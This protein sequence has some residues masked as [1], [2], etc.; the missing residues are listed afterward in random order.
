M[1]ER[2]VHEVGPHGQPADVALVEDLRRGLVLGR[3]GRP[4]RLVP[5]ERRLHV[6]G[7]IEPQPVRLGDPQAHLEGELQTT[8]LRRPGGMLERVQHREHA[9]PGLADHVVGRARARARRPARAARAGTARATRTRPAR[10]AGA[11]CGR[12]RAGRR[13]RRRGRSPPAP[14]W[15]RGSRASR[16]GRRGTGSPAVGRPG[17]ISPITRYQ[18]RCPSQVEERPRCCFHVALHLRSARGPKDG[19]A[20][21]AT[22]VTGVPVAMRRASQCIVALSSRTQPWET[23]RARDAADVREAVQGGLCGAAVERVQH[24]RASAQRERERCGVVRGGQRDGLLDVEA[25]DRRRCRR[26]AHDRGEGLRRHVRRRTP[27]RV[28]SRD[29]PRSATACAV[30]RCVRARSSRRDRS[31]GPGA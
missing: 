11:R 27:S 26:L 31:G 6:L 21:Q 1:R 30:R 16:R 7:Q 17:V 12:C 10:R 29:R 14:P 9:A 3:V 4:V 20:A 19:T 18:V 25:A 24:G 2:A 5:R 23:A 22:I 28:A 15:T 8:M 13:R